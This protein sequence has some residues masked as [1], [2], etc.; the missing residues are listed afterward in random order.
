MQKG[1]SSTQAAG[2]EISE[3]SVYCKVRRKEN[4]LKAREAAQLAGARRAAHS[5]PSQHSSAKTS[6]CRHSAD[7]ARRARMRATQ[8][9]QDSAPTRKIAKEGESVGLV[10]AHHG[11]FFLRAHRSERVLSEKPFLKNLN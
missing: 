11:E 7:V 9:S 1:A 6:Q 10:L 3:K 8:R 2:K 4:Y 5:P